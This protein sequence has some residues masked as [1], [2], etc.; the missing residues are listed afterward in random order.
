MIKNLQESV[1]GRLVDSGTNDSVIDLVLAALDGGDALSAVLAGEPAAPRPDP[2]AERVSPREAFLSKLTVQGFRG[3]GAPTVLNLSPG[4]GLTVIAGRNGSGKSSLSEALECALTGTTVRW[5][6]KLGHAEFRSGWRNLH[7]GEPCAIELELNQAGRGPATLRVAWPKGT[8]DPG[9]AVSTYQIAGQKR[10]QADLGWQAAIQNYRPLLSY[11]DLGLLLTAKPSELHDSIARAL[12]LD[13]LDAAVNL[14]G[15]ASAPLKAPLKRAGEIRRA[16]KADLV[17]VD[18][19]RARTAVKLLGKTA[20]DLDAL[21]TLVAGPRSSDGPLQ[22]CEWILA[23]QLPAAEDVEAAAV[24]LGQAQAELVGVGERRSQAEQLRDRLLSEALEYHDVA[25]DSTCPVCST[26]SLDVDWRQRTQTVL[27]ET[28]LVRVARS[29]AEGR[30]RAATSQVRNLIS[31]APGILEQ[32]Q[33]DLPSQPDVAA[34][35]N[36]WTSEAAAPSDQLQTRYQKLVEALARW[37]GD[38]ATYRDAVAE[39]WSPYALR[40]ATL[41]ADFVDALEQNSK[42]A[43]IDAAYEAAASI[44]RQ[45]KQE[46]LQPI[47]DQTKEIWAQL[48]QESNVTL[49]DVELTGKGNRRAVDI[50]AVVDDASAGSALSVMSQGELNALALALYLPRATSDESPFRFLV[51]DDPVQAMDPTKVDGLAT[52]LAEIALTR[53]VIVFSHDDRF[54]Q[55]ARRLPNPPTVLSVRRDSQSSVIVQRDLQ[56]AQRNLDDAFALLRETNMD[57]LVKRRVMPVILRTAIEAA[58]WQ[59]HSATRLRAGDRL[60]EVEQAWERAERTRAR[61]ELIHGTSMNSWMNRDQR[62]SRA[63]ARCN[64]GAHQP[65]TGNLDEAYEDAKSV[66]QAIESGLG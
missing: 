41:V 53:Q 1:F 46:R 4:P 37:Q 9:T 6:R 45:L 65:M 40:L 16:L 31:P 38:A 24:E 43:A 42:A 58:A 64:A 19:D 21:T 39:C 59:R 17:G 51:L 62:R 32:T 28:D 66:V 33:V 34:V 14:L 30:L 23:V 36:E 61:L 7:H 48:R 35:W 5:E 22:I 18:D 10:E 60:D 29:Q 55:A 27:A 12:A 57:D 15:E 50:R 11:D 54:A 25:G 26:G 44:G 3:I 47:V 2:A 52:V 20:P 8:T 63:V 56:P 13:Q 49:E